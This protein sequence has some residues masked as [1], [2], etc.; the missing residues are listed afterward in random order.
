M[1]EDLPDKAMGQ[2]LEDRNLTQMWTAVQKKYG[3][4]GINLTTKKA[5]RKFN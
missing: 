4:I 2:R 3:R 5:F 1:Q